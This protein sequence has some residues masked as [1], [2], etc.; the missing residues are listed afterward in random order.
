MPGVAVEPHPLK[1]MR[2][3]QEEQRLPGSAD[4]SFVANR[5][6]SA[7]LPLQTDARPKQK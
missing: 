6:V 4:S 2:L 1:A 7:G 3:T 5:G